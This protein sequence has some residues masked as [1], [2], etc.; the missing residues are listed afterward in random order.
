MTRCKETLTLS[1][2]S[3]DEVGIELGID[4]EMGVVVVGHEF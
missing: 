2:R 3:S 4:K 1:R